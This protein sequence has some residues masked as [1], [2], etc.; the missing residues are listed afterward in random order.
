[1][2]CTLGVFACG[3]GGGGAADSDSSESGEES[4]SSSADESSS[5]GED[6]PEM[7]CGDECA[8]P[9]EIVWQTTNGTAVWE[10]AFASAISPSGRIAVTGPVDW[11]PTGGFVNVYEPN[12]GTV[13]SGT[14]VESGAGLAWDSP[15][16]FVIA[17]E[18]PAGAVNIKRFDENGAELWTQTASESASLGAFARTAAGG[19]VVGGGTETSGLIARFDATGGPLTTISTPIDM[20]VSDL[21]V[22]SDGIVAIG[23][24][25]TENPWI[26]KY[27]DDDVL[28]WSH[29]GVAVDAKAIAVTTNGTVF[30]SVRLATG[31]PQLLR[32]APDGTPLA[33]V[34][35]PWTS[36][37]IVEMTPS[38]DGGVLLATSNLVPHTHCTITR[39]SVTGVMTWGVAFTDLADNECVGVHAAADDAIVATG[40]LVGQDGDE[41]MWIVQIKR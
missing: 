40:G 26:G 16:T 9:P 21:A 38:V 33:D 14:M 31:A 8:N 4:S 27:G 15:T 18:S 20:F 23:T 25:L 22:A 13:Y 11:P 34:P 29:Q 19:F 6:I 2:A 1:L 3:G 39:V 36:A 37:L 12:G 30:A 24:D 41:D 28:Q 10:S 17:G 7:P 5:T 35:L 32:F